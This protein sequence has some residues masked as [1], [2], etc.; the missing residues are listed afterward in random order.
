PAVAP[1]QADTAGARRGAD[2]M[3]AEVVPVWSRQMEVTRDVASDGLAKILNTFSE[4]L[5][6][7]N[8]LA[9][10]AAEAGAT[11]TPGAV[12]DAVRSQSP[13]LAALTSASARAFAERDAAVAEL[14]RCA[15][16]LVELQQLTK[17]ARE[18]A[19]HTRLVAF[20]ASI[21]SNR[22]QGGQAGGSQAVASELRMLSGRIGETAEQMERVMRKLAASIAKVCRTSE[23]RDTTPDELRL[24]IEISAR[25]ALQALLSGLG[26]GLQGPAGL[27]QT[28][29]A[30][31]DQVEAAF[32]DF[33]FGDRVSQMLSIIANDMNNFTRWV[34]SNPR[35]TQN[36]A[37]EWLASLEASYT[38][39]EQRSSHHG[40]VNVE[41]GTG[42]DFF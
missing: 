6:A 4:I 3:V 31:A 25:N 1:G 33:Q 7:L 35:A 17:Q 11:A 8:T 42:V 39:D 23:V 38:M 12:D 26:G 13:A 27:Q 2:V 15:D 24:E 10:G 28:S 21:E 20:N 18:L 19:R 32:M 41:V 36:D 22:Q 16:G 14:S 34:G 37:A 29:R 9:E 30:I 5:G 40:N